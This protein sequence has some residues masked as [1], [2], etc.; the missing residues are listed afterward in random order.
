VEETN[1]N[2]NP[3]TGQDGRMDVKDRCNRC[4]MQQRISTCRFCCV[5]W[6]TNRRPRRKPKLPFWRIAKIF[7]Q[8]GFLQMPAGAGDSRNHPP[9]RTITPSS[10]TGTLGITGQQ[11]PSRGAGHDGAGNVDLYLN[12]N[13][14]GR[15]AVVAADTLLLAGRAQIDVA[16]ETTVNISARAR[17]LAGN[18][19]AHLYAPYRMEQR[20]A[21]G[22]NNVGQL[23]NG[24]TADSAFPTSLIYFP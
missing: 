2:K 15:V 16:D 8:R 19:S 3:I 24:T 20:C 6:R 10:Y 1:I 7:Q 14:E 17:H 11:Q 12:R 5:F 9:Q 22:W 4:S 13:C 23:R 18:V 21:G